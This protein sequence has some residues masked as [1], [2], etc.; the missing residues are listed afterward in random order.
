MAPHRGH[1]L[2]MRAD[3]A[4]LLKRDADLPAV[5]PGDATF[6]LDGAVDQLETLGQHHAGV[7]LQAYAAR[8]II[9]DEAIDQRR[10]GIDRDLAGA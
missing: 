9:D 2:F 4:R 7:D 10:L 8:A 6:L 1:F 5:D 3:L